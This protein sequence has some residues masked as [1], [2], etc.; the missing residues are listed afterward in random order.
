M[1]HPAR[2]D[3]LQYMN[4]EKAYSYLDGARDASDGRIW[5]D[6]NVLK[7][8]DMAYDLADQIAKLPPTERKKNA[9]LLL[10]DLLHRKYPCRQEGGKR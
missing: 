3:P 9:S 4:R 1:T 8:P 6:V 2:L 10:L 7:T 5:C